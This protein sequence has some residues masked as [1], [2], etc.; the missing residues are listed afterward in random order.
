M[1]RLSLALLLVML[2]VVSTSKEKRK[3][4]TGLASWYGPGFVGKPMANGKPF[5][6]RRLTAASKTLPLGTKIK[7]TCLKTKRH[8]V[9]TVTD[10]GPYVRPRI[11]DLSAEAARR[12]GMKRDGVSR[13][14][15]EVL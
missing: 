13:V 8:V 9:V 4:I 3:A 1:K 6:P 2:F 7:V 14:R 12:I 11:L 5:D 15:I 10:R